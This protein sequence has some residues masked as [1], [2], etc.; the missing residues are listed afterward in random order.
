M[1][2]D[3]RFFATVLLTATVGG[4]WPQPEGRP[5]VAPPKGCRSPPNRPA[6]AT[7]RALRS[8]L[9][10]PARESSSPTRKSAGWRW[11]TPQWRRGLLTERSSARSS[12]PRECPTS[13]RPAAHRSTMKEC[14]FV[15]GATSAVLVAGTRRT[16]RRAA[17]GP[18]HLGGPA[19]WKRGRKFPASASQGTAGLD[20]RNGCSAGDACAPS[21][22]ERDRCMEPRH[23]RRARYASA[24]SGR[25]IRRR[26]RRL[27]GGALLDAALRRLRP[28]LRGRWGWPCWSCSEEPGAG[29]SRDRGSGRLRGDTLWQRV[30]TLPPVPLPPQNV[31]AEVD[32][33]AAAVLDRISPELAGRKAREALYAPTSFPPARAVVPT[34]SGELWIATHESADSMNVWYAVARGESERAPRRVLLPAWFRLGDATSTHVW[35]VRPSADGEP[36]QPRQPLGLRLVPPRQPDVS[37]APN[38]ARPGR[39]A[40]RASRRAAAP[41]GR[42][43]ARPCAPARS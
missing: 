8:A 41:S 5:G 35:G 6:T 15:T 20:G 12:R 42:P 43:A 25:P 22:T 10:A 13:A 18:V 30:L 23:R 7:D 40:G 24:V 34:V 3:G 31:E 36:R 16:S 38:A 32:A 17:A 28:P 21:P 27:P 39:V 11:P 33:L 1:P 37:P 9:T 29:P 4:C 2:S 14:G 26:D 19:R